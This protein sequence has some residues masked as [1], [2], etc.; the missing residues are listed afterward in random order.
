MPCHTIRD[1]GV[2]VM[3]RVCPTVVC[4]KGGGG[5][6]ASTLQWP[7][8]SIHWAGCWTFTKGALVALGLCQSFGLVGKHTVA[9]SPSTHCISRRVALL[10]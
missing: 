3:V 2:A 6:L 7:V 5:S 8:P 4:W 10:A 1:E 9:G